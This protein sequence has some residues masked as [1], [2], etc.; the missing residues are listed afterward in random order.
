MQPEAG[1][2]DVSH[3]AARGKNDYASFS[4][5]ARLSGERSLIERALAVSATAGETYHHDGRTSDKNSDST[6]LRAEVT[7][8]TASA[9]SA[10][11]HR[12]PIHVGSG[13]LPCA[14]VLSR[15]STAS[16]ASAT[17]CRRRFIV[18]TLPYPLRRD[19]N[20]GC[21]RFLG[22]VAG[23]PNR[24]TCRMPCFLTAAGG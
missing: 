2:R 3:G 24:P 17:P 10:S 4:G 11:S 22:E 13:G 6:V 18:R 8:L 16:R 21:A 23:K 19:H 12:P 1:V 7:R 20:T 14:S 15:T 5:G 9:K